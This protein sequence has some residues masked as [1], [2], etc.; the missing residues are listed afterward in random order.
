MLKKYEKQIQEL[1][2]LGRRDLERDGIIP[3]RQTV[4]E[5]DGKEFTIPPSEMKFASLNLRSDSAR[6]S[7]KKKIWL[8]ARKNPHAK[9]IFLLH[10]RVIYEL[11]DLEKYPNRLSLYV[12]G[13]TSEQEI[14]IR[15]DY[16]FD[17]SGKPVFGEVTVLDHDPEEAFLDHGFL[18]EQALSMPDKMFAKVP[19]DML[20]ESF[21]KEWLDYLHREREDRDDDDWY[22]PKRATESSITDKKEGGHDEVPVAEE[23]V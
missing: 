18:A 23:T 5:A 16:T 6:M 22:S 9:A 11:A 14:F 19:E 7:H 21:P 12:L 3:I 1:L 15:Q 17:N 10:D 2:A 4:V 13:L 20:A 8:S